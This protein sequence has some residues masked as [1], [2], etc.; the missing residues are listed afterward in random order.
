MTKL[1][2]ILFALT[3]ITIVLLSCNSQKESQQVVVEKTAELAYKIDAQLGEGAYWNHRTQELYWVDI[4]A[5]Q[6]NVFD[7][8]KNEN[9]SFD[10]PSRGSSF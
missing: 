1:N 2:Q 10:C 3:A 9:R 7:P 4:E 5:K 6:M 8:K